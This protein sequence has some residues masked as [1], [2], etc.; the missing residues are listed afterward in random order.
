MLNPPF[1][2][3]DP[4]GAPIKNIIKQ[5]KAKDIFLCHSI[6]CFEIIAFLYLKSSVFELLT[7]FKILSLFIAVS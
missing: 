3:I 1:L 4:K 6:L 7:D 2:I 5:A